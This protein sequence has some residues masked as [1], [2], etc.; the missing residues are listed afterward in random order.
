MLENLILIPYRNRQKH[1]DY[2][3]KHTVPLIEKNMPETR[4]LVIE[5]KEG[6]L[7][8]R[9]CVLNIGF[10]EY[11]KKTKYFITH[12]VDINPTESCL[13]NYYSPGIKDKIRGIL[14]SPCVTLSPIV[15]IP[16][17]S[18]FKMNG[19]PNDIWGWG[20][21][22]KALENRR[23]YFKIEKEIIFINNNKERDDEHFKIFNDIKDRQTINHN[24]N[25]K[26]YNN[27]F[28]RSTSEEQKE[29]IFNSGL[30]NLKYQV[31]KRESLH[32]IVDLIKVEI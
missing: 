26:K 20:I 18:I 7:F 9:G 4:V 27:L 12:D 13:K 29:N 28:W 11:K 14:V 2:F 21:E 17:E 6:K 32:K 22:D 31:I 3:I 30:N 8:N 1:L 19:F 15:K 25:K 23:D 5:Q 24:F 10:K 16:H